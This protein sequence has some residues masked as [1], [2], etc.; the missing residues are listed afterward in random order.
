MAGSHVRYT[1]C[2]WLT[3]AANSLD[4]AASISSGSPRR[5]AGN[6]RA[7]NHGSA[8]SEQSIDCCS[9]GTAYQISIG[10]KRSD[11]TVAAN[12]ATAPSSVM[13]TSVTFT[14]GHR[15]PCCHLTL[16]DR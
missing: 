10:A 6:S 3:A 15:F 11:V 5:M 9:E 13:V 16:H 8:R 1:V 4:T 2:R 7:L 12:R 14:S